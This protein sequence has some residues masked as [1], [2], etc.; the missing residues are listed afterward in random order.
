MHPSAREKWFTGTKGG[1]GLKSLYEFPFARHLAVHRAGILRKCSKTD[2]G[3]RGRPSFFRA[4]FFFFSSAPSSI[5][6]YPPPF[7]HVS[8]LKRPVQPSTDELSTDP[9]LP[10]PSPPG[11][12]QTSSNVNVLIKLSGTGSIPFNSLGIENRTCNVLTRNHCSSWYFQTICFTRKTSMQRK[13]KNTIE[14]FD[15]ERLGWD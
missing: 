9:S 5:H 1:I 10:P 12:F 2:R 11:Y 14:K 15:F 13:R 3:Q 4:T 6:R 8:T 7:T